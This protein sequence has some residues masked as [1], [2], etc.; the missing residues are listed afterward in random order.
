MMKRMKTYMLGILGAG[1]LAL[2]LATA[3]VAQADDLRVNLN[4]GAAPVYRVGPQPVVVR[5]VV[6]QPRQVVYQ[7]ERVVYRPQPQKIVI[8]E[9]P[10]RT[11]VREYY[12][13]YQ[14]PY[15]WN[16]GHHGGWGHDRY[17]AWR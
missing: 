1:L 3:S 13:P 12:R 2:P 7:Q 8:V 5:Q 14:R 11:I 16:Q 6:Q 17:V 9:R 15:A 4:L 10:H